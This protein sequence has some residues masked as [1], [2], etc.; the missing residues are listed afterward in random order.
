[1][2]WL[3]GI[4]GVYPAPGVRRRSKEEFQAKLKEY[5]VDAVITGNCGCGLC[6]QKE[7]GAAIAAEYIGIP[8][9]A[10][11]APRVAEYPGAFALHTTEELIANTRNIL[12][13]RIVKA[14]TDPIT[15]QELNR[16]S[17]D[18]SRGVTDDIFYGTTEQLEE[19]LI[20]LPAD[21]PL[22]AFLPTTTPT[23]AATQS[24]DA[25]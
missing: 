13:Q 24:S 6:T 19:A 23:Q 11:A 22:S 8:A 1:M 7:C 3:V 15:E 2:Q 14:L 16:H 25:Q 4:A 5:G 10:I 18:A 20:K 17:V 21:Q 12:W 9:V